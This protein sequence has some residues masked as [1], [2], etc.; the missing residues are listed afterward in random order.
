MGMSALSSSN[1]GVKYILTVIDVL[2]KFGWCEPMKSKSAEATTEAFVAI[3]ERA[4]GL[5]PT[6]LGTYKG[7][8]FRNHIFMVNRIASYYIYVTRWQLTESMST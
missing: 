1:D 4:Q 8:K 3:L 5:K 7:S 6:V 2:S